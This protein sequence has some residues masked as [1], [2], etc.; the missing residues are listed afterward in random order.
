LKNPGPPKILMVDDESWNLD[1]L[2]SHLRK[3]GWEPA[4]VMNGPEALRAVDENEFDLILLDVMMPGMDGF[5][6]CRQ[7]RARERLR[8]IPVLLVTALHETED[9]VKGLEAGA[10]DF[11]T[12][13]VQSA[14][15]VAR[16]RAHLRLKELMDI[17]LAQ[18]TH[19]ESAYRRLKE[20]S[21]EQNRMTLIVSHELRSPLS[22]ITMILDY[23]FN[24][25]PET[26]SEK[27]KTFLPRLMAHIR[28]LNELADGIL[29]LKAMENAKAEHFI[30]EKCDLNL[31]VSEIVEIQ[32]PVAEAKGCYM[33]FR[34]DPLL[35]Q[36][37]ADR[38]RLT[39]M[40]M[41]LIGNAIKYTPEGGVTVSTRRLPL[42]R[43]Y[44]IEISDTGPGM[45]EEE[46]K[47]LFRKF[48]R[49]QDAYT[50]GIRGSGLGLY[51]TRELALKHGGDIVV[52]S[53]PGKGSCFSV[54][55]PEDPD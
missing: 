49:L 52:E 6:V 15:L 7:I 13:P 50:K 26:L 17:T 29:D 32:R 11:L 14:E 51:I 31:L 24:R 9:K 22:A 38:Q 19:L 18:K 36:V 53:V 42:P 2:A 40:L 23:Y 37:R 30:F 28:R 48:G 5:E 46:Q 43:T 10:S 47:G 41:N 4:A 21:E 39:Q 25:H 45:S 3:E 27:Q 16:V 20:L 44:R 8:Q 1:V 12:K 35:G 54:V 34:P 55:L 33:N